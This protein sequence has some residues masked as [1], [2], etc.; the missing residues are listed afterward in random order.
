VSKD[1]SEKIIVTHIFPDLDA[2]GAV[3]ML[4]RFDSEWGKAEVKFV[5]SGLTYEEK[6]VDSDPSVLHVDT[7]MGRFDHHQE[8]EE[9]TCA[10]ELVF[11]YLKSEN[12]LPKKYLKGA[13]RLVQLIKQVDLFEDY[14]YPDPAGDIY[15]VMISSLLNYLKL[16]G[17]LNDKELLYQGMTLLDAA[18]FG[19]VQKVKAEEEI[20]K[21][22]EFNSVWG[23]CLGLEV[24]MGGL[25]KLG[26]KKGFDLVV[27]KE[28]DTGFVSIKSAPKEELDLTRA[29]EELQKKDSRAD[30]FF[31]ASKH[32]ILNGSRHNPKV[33]PSTLSLVELIEILK[34][35]NN[36]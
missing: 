9:K 24:Q 32:I 31:H 28:P 13:E 17:R 26:L 25:A 6:E 33:K 36:I 35:I 2:I 27:I 18:L 4:Q 30:W 7:G 10:T 5:A 21:G 11:N 20:N 23:K 12:K 34:N 1:L 19:L 16:S 8:L 29:Y 15:D 3:W 14:D 22:V